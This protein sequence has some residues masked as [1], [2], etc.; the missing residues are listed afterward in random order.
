[1]RKRLIR[2]VVCALTLSA[3]LFS[4]EMT[5]QNQQT[6]RQ[7]P[8][9]RQM[10]PPAPSLGR[11]YLQ[12]V[13][14]LDPPAENWSKPTGP[15]KVV[16][17]VDESLP[18]HTIYRPADLAAFPAKDKLP[19]IIMS[20]PGCDFDGDSYRPFWT[21]IASHGY[22]VI[23]VGLPVPE[24]LRA[25][26]FFNK[27]E[28][29]KDGLDWAFAV[30]KRNASKFY[31]KLD[32]TNVVLMG[33]SC[34]GM[35]MTDLHN[36]SRVTMMVYWNSGVGMMRAPGTDQESP[37]EFLK[38]ITRPL[39][40][41]AGDTDMARQGSTSNFE[42]VAK[43]PCLLAVRQIPGDSHGGT[44]RENNGGAFGVAAVAWL[45]WWTK[46]DEEAGKMFLGE[47]SGLEKD[48]GWVEVRRKNLR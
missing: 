1:M 36:D 16:M 45:D 29:V 20:G 31:G 48:P 13:N 27:T 3:G 42:T 25:A 19:V 41:F 43:A 39:A 18:N 26:M 40:F 38:T 8:P 32:T 21:E 10:A 12:M 30:T 22:F 35:I 7:Q 24:G 6:Q 47:K 28:D 46:G 17:E 2:G 9:R 23:A 33:Q 5:A 4:A 37:G 11:H 34:G 15:Y 44:F 14:P